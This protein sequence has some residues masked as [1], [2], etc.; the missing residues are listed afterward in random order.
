MYTYELLGMDELRDQVFGDSYLPLLDE[1]DLSGRTPYFSGFHYFAQHHLYGSFM[2][3]NPEPHF[4]VARE[5]GTESPFDIVGVL[6][7]G[8]YEEGKDVPYYAVNYIDVREDHKINGIATNL[9]KHLNY[10][11]I[12]HDVLVGTD[13]SLEG[14]AAKL[15]DIIAR[16]FHACPYHKNQWDFSEHLYENGI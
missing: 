3:K 1:I 14:Q 4:L 16:E 11:L 10:V 7:L 2:D 15:K 6:K 8:R 12:E 9:I 5:E 13:L